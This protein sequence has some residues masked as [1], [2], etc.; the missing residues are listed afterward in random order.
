MLFYSDLSGSPFPITKMFVKWN[1]LDKEEIIANAYPKNER[2]HISDFKGETAGVNPDY[3]V[4]EERCGAAVLLL[5]EVFRKLSREQNLLLVPQDKG[6]VW[7]YRLNGTGPL[8]VRE[9][10]KALE[11]AQEVQDASSLYYYDAMNEEIHR[12]KVD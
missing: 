11:I 3:I 12:L 10:A 7:V 9:K 8:S 4:T 5:E 2:I 6:Q 1:H